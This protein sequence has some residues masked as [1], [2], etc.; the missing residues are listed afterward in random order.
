MRSYVN[1]IRLSN[2]FTRL[3][4]DGNM[5]YSVDGSSGRID[6]KSNEYF[7]ANLTPSELS[8]LRNE[9]TGY[10]KRYK[11]LSTKL[12]LN[13]DELT[14]AEKN[15]VL[16]DNI[17]RY[18]EVTGDAGAYGFAG[19]TE[20]MTPITYEKDGYKALIVNNKNLGA[21]HYNSDPNKKVCMIIATGDVVVEQDFS[22]VIIARGCVTINNPAV[23]KISANKEAIYK[24]L[25]YEVAPEETLVERFFRDGDKYV[26]DT[27]GG[28]VAQGDYVTY[29]DLITYEEW[30][31]K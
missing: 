10:M 31:K 19:I 3:T 8:G 17:I 16:F 4:T 29:R 11:A 15:R 5:I 18:N 21:Y 9:E 2:F 25:Q 24:V 7:G 12:V 22:G 27:G 23:N 14:L 26:L 20:S 28:A 30:T 1:E 13:Y 6:L